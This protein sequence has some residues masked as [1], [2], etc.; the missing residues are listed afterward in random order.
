VARLGSDDCC[1]LAVDTSPKPEPVSVA[2]R[3]A[4]VDAADS[5][6][7]DGFGQRPVPILHPP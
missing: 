6:L 1:E 4:P 7:K 2:R 3:E 5:S